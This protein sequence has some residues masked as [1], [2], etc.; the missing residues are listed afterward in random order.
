MRLP[1]KYSS[2][3]CSVTTEAIRP[4]ERLR[5]FCWDSRAAR[6]RAMKYSISALLAACVLAVTTANA[7]DILIRGATVHTVTS[8][9]T[10]DNADVLLRD[11]KIQAVGSG[12]TAGAGAV[13]IEAKGRALTPGMFAGLTSIGI[14]EVSAEPTTDDA[15]IALGAPAYETQ[16]RPEF[17]V[18]TAFN[19]RSL[20]IPVTR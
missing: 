4:R 1:N 17:D 8:K 10:L 11:G 14:Q 7:Q 3:A 6:E 18:T 2:T 19:N 20:L 13:V 5:I 15:S 9:G 12:L 16:W